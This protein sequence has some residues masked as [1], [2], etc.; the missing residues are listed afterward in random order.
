M[1]SAWL[2]A[3]HRS[4]QQMNMKWRCAWRTGQLA[5]VLKRGSRS[6]L[7]NFN[8]HERDV[9]GQR[10]MAET[11][12]L[13]AYTSLVSPTGFSKCSSHSTEFVL[14]LSYDTESPGGSIATG[15]ATHARRVKVMTQT[16]WDTLVLQVGGWA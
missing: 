6:P 7:C 8:G 9:H 13:M 14:A 3:D 1:W 10:L 12:E 5:A 11:P 15:R 16:K 2:P 4:S